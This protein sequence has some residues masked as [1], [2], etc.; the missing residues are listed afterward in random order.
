MSSSTGYAVEAGLSYAITKDFGLFASVAKLRV[1]SKVVA[2]GTT[3]LQTDVD[4][5]PIVYSA[6]VSYQF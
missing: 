4:F 2:T 6:G 3:V 5:R 1:K